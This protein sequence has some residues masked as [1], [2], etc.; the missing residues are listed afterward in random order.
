VQQPKLAD[1]QFRHVRFYT[2]EG[3]LDDVANLFHDGLS[4]SA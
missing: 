1:I 3:G 2:D 4:V